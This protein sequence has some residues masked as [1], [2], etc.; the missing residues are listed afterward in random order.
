M[1]SILVFLAVLVALPSMYFGLGYLGLF[2]INFWGVKYQDARTNVFQE[3]KAYRHGT[4]RDIENLCIEIE[5][6]ETTTHKN[7]LRAT[8]NH[9]IAA[10]DYNLLPS[11]VKKCIE[12]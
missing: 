6:A 8:L 7:A 2:G 3:T 10:F 5:K 12:S 9:R 11:H 4:I 1:K